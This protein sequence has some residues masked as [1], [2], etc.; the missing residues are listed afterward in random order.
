VAGF[1]FPGI[2]VVVVVVVVAVGHSDVC[3]CAVPMARV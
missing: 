3:V 2:V 1:F